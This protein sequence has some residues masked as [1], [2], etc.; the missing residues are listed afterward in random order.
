MAVF[1][2]AAGI[3]HFIHPEFYLAIM[4]PY[5]PWHSA[6]VLISGVAELVLGIL[7]IPPFTRKLAA[8]GI[9]LLLIAVFPANV[10]MLLNY[11]QENN[12]KTWLAILRLPIQGLLIWWAYQYT[13]K[14]DETESQKTH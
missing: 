9:I 1:Y 8:W 3:N 6:L 5:L 4:P 14:A 11:I 7:L 13:W 12:P 10:Q 2:M